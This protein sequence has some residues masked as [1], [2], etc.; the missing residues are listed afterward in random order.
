MHHRL[1][2]VLRA[3]LAST[4]A[5]R[6]RMCRA[7]IF[8]NYRIIHRHVGGALLKFADGISP[9]LH[10]LADQTLRN[11]DRSSG[12]VH[13]PALDFVPT[14]GKTG[15]VGGGE[16]ADGELLSA[17]LAKL[18]YPFC[19]ARISLL[20][21]NP[22]VFRP[23]AFPQFLAATFAHG[24]KQDSSQGDYGYD[25]NYHQELSLIHALSRSTTMCC[26][27]MRVPAGMLSKGF[28][29]L[30]RPQ[31]VCVDTVDAIRSLHQTDCGVTADS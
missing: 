4:V 9:G 8:H 15:S 27:G 5:L 1:Q 2:Q 29:Q 10:Y 18:Q 12:I 26:Y 21:Y 11:R 6:D 14:K 30:W 31:V 16:W 23:K 24:E 28:L 20:L 22:I 3:G 25:D 17:F 7:L 13:K 19:L